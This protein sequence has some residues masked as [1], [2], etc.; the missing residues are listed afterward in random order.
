MSCSQT[1][2]TTQEELN[3]PSDGFNIEASDQKAIVIADSVME[4][5]GG[6]KA[7]DELRYVSWNF[8]GARD[9]VWDK[10]TGRVRIDFPPRNETYLINVNDETGKVYVGDSLVAPADSLKLKVD[11]GKSIWINDSYWL[12][13]PFKLKDSGVTLKYA[14][15]DTLPGGYPAHVL[16]LTFAGVGVTPENKYEVYVDM[17]DYLVKQ[18]CYFQKASQDSASAVWPWDNY[19]SYGGLMLSADR[20]DNRGPKNVKVYDELPDGVF[21]DPNYNM[22]DLIISE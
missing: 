13:M 7:W 20:S 3:P 2:E 15:E 22:S 18:W 4:A 10:Q 21:S 8:F 11:Q 1:K 19:A 6:R 17:E 14:R 9:L 5:M 16:Q 12:F